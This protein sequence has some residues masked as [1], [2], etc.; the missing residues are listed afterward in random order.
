MTTLDLTPQYR[1]A[2]RAQ[3]HSLKPVVL[4]GEQGLN[5][6]NLAEID[7]ALKAHELIKVR[8]FGDDA[9]ARMDMQHAI[10][11]ALGA[12]PVQAIGKLLVLY[13]P[14]PKETRS[15]DDDAAAVKHGKS[16]RRIKLVVPSK[17]PTHR[18]KVKRVTV[19]GN[20]RVTATGKIKRAKPRTTSV[21]KTTRD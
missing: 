15:A 12:A 10:C 4:I 8:I 13:R 16:P 20:Q 9:Q 1:S 11:D 21:K 3:A 14:R 18:P 6:A 17:S 19:L 7:G 2:L 5:P